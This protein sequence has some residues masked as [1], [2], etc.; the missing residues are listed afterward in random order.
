MQCP[1]TMLQEFILEL[2]W[3]VM[4]HLQVWLE[5]FEIYRLRCLLSISQKMEGREELVLGY[6]SISATLTAN[7]GYP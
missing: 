5:V 3:N 1:G 2:F 6:I 4:P 7:I